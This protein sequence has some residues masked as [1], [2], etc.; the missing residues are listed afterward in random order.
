MATSDHLAPSQCWPEM[1]L[2]VL[3]V[4]DQQRNRRLNGNFNPSGKDLLSPRMDWSQ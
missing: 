1:S 2:H 4:A 3:W